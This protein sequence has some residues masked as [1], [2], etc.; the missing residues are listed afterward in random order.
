MQDEPCCGGKILFA[1]H[2][3]LIT[4]DGVAKK[5]CKSVLFFGV[6]YSNKGL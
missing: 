3:F 5:V 1:L 4:L 6:I 2:S